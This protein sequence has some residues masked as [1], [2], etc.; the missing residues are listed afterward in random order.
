MAEDAGAGVIPA[1]GLGSVSEGDHLR[2]AHGDA[3]RP[4]DR[5]ELLD[6]AQGCLPGLCAAEGEAILDERARHVDHDDGNLAPPANG[7]AR[8]LSGTTSGI[9]ALARSSFHSDM[10]LLLGPSRRPGESGPQTARPTGSGGRISC[11][12]VAS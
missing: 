10:A 11:Q 6:A 3:N 2:K 1:A 5:K 8:S 9:Y 12:W 7:M 4:G